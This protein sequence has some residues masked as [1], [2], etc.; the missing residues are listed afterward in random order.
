MSSHEMG[1]ELTMYSEEGRRYIDKHTAVL[2]AE[3][4]EWQK[5]VVCP[6]ISSPSFGIKDEQGVH[7]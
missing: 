1:R 4:A 2:S 6:S 5:N 3:E 7:D